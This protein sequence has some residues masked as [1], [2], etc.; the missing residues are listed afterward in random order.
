M[1]FPISGTHAIWAMEKVTMLFLMLFML[2]LSHK[3]NYQQLLGFYYI[4]PD[5]Y[6][7]HHH[8]LGFNDKHNEHYSI[9][10]KQYFP[11]RP[12]VYAHNTPLPLKKFQVTGWCHKNYLC[13]KKLWFNLFFDSFILAWHVFWLMKILPLL[14]F[15]FISVV[16]PIP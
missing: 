12:I 14:N 10:Y 8:T 7:K 4:Q 6:I 15:P 11:K 2:I 5:V 1:V 13:F 16:C 9:L 3:P